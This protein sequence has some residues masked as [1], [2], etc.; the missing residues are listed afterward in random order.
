MK[1]IQVYNCHR[2]RDKTFILGCKARNVGGYAYLASVVFFL[3]RSVYLKTGVISRRT[4]DALTVVQK[5]MSQE[6]RSNQGL[7]A[8]CDTKYSRLL[9]MA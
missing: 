2:T 7:L 5:T 6:P 1:A 3:D 8:T 4:G 9:Y